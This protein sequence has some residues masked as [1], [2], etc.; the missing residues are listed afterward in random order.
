MRNLSS[1]LALLVSG[2]AVAADLRLFFSTDDPL[3]SQHPPM[4][5]P[6]AAT[7][8]INVT[9]QPGMPLES[10]EELTTQVSAVAIGLNEVHRLHLWGTGSLG[11]PVPNIW[12]GIALRF[13]IDGPGAIV[14]GGMLNVTSP[15]SSRRWQSNSDFSVMEGNVNLQGVVTAGL[16]LPV[17][18]DGWDNGLD[19]VYL[20]YLDITGNGGMSDVFIQPGTSGIT[21]RDGSQNED[22]VYF[23]WDGPEPS[24]FPPFW[25]PDARI[26]PEPSGLALAT[27]GLMLVVRGRRSP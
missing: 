22:N 11:E 4:P 26:I 2:T 9:A 21:R 5:P 1:V 24:D 15:T 14:G 17:S 27:I 6:H 18:G 23:G 3:G 8:A 10:P 13:V 16:Q 20:G 7:N 12:D 25:L 19:A